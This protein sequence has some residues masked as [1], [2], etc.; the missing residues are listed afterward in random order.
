MKYE[1]INKNNALTY[2]SDEDIRQAFDSKEPFKR[3]IVRAMGLTN[4]E[5]YLPYLYQALYDESFIIRLDAAQSIFTIN[6]EKGL[7]EL[8]KR[9]EAIDDSELE[10][11]PSEKANLLA[12]I[13]RIEKG[14]EG[15]KEYILSDDG[16][17]IVKY[18]C[19]T[20]YGCGY[21]YHEEDVELLWFVMDCFLNKEK[22]WMKDLSYQEYREFIYFGLESI[23][24][25]GRESDI[26]NKVSE[27]LNQKIY[28]MITRVMN[29]KPTTDM[30]ELIAEISKYMKEPY[31]K[32]ILALLKHH[33]S[34][35]AKREFKKSLK[36]WNITEEEL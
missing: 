12:R 4:N 22:K 11:E 7:S 27:E 9:N 3:E 25:A 33:V 16:Y 24:L 18:C 28:H 34:G 14:V 2:V 20:Y 29:Q 17:D 36:K 30:K 6:A 35:D 31:A 5:D 19:I 32:K 23:W 26:L 15:I 13:I 8:K 1:V 21:R 10:T